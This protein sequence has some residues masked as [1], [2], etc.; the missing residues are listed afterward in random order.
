MP[1][2]RTAI[3]RDAAEN[4]RPIVSTRTM[5]IAVALCTIGVSALILTDSLRVGAGWLDPVGPQAGYF[6]FYV[7]ALMGVAAFIILAR[8]VMAGR[9]PQRTFVRDHAFRRVLLVLVPMA[10]FIAVT[11]YV[12]LYLAA[13]VY[14]GA[15]MRFIGQYSLLRSA[16]VAIAVPLALFFM[17]EIW[18]LVPLPKGPIEDMLG[19]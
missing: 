17:F 7:G 18:F 9:V 15:F 13:A 11:Q 3:G 8:A 16:A 2:H 14:I 1:E 5:E 12:G 6:P 4:D 19:F 10:V